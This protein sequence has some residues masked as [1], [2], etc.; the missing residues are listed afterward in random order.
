MADMRE[1]WDD[2]KQAQRARRRMRLPERQAEIRALTGKGFDVREFNSGYQFRINGELDL[3]PVHRR[4]HHV[5]TQQRGPY[6]NA[7]STAVKFLR[8]EAT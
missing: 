2:Y 5:P 8:V 1:A 6:E 4:Y 3:F 7:L